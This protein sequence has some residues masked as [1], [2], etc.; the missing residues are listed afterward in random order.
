MLTVMLHTEIERY[1]ERTV[2]KNPHFPPSNFKMQIAHLG[3]TFAVLTI[4]KY[5]I[6]NYVQSKAS[7]VQVNHLQ[8]MRTH[9]FQYTQL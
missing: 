9:M 1:I 5:C 4:S 6:C 3:R 7:Q 8:T 2:L